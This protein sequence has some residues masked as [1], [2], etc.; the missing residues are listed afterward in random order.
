MKGNIYVIAGPSGVGKGTVLKRVFQ[1]DDNLSLSISATTRSPRVGEIDGVNYYFVTRER[2]DQIVAED[3]FLEYAEYVG[4]RYGTPLKPVLDK[5]AEGFDVILEIEVQGCMQVM[6][7]L[8]EAK[9]IFILPPSI[10]ALEKRLRG[11]ESEP[12][13]VIR[14]RLDTAKIE[15]GHVNKFDY[16]VVNDTIENAANQIVNIIKSNR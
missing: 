1:L 15:L 9:G 6:D 14:K 4:N 8:P 11:R 3:G 13:D 16:F 10:E 12:D 5:A 7:K 2:F